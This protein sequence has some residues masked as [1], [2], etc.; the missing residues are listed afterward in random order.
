M[1]QKRDERI[2]FRNIRSQIGYLVRPFVLLNIYFLYTVRK[3]YNN[4][5]PA[6]HKT[7]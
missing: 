4:K 3:Q 6:V 1:K 7:A 5:V 2:N